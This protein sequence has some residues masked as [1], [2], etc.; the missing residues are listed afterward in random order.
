MKIEYLSEQCFMI[1]LN[2]FYLKEVSFQ[3]KIDLELYFKSFFLKLKNCY[4]ITM[5]GFY[6]IDVYKDK[7]YGMILKIK[8]EDFD[9]FDDEMIDMKLRIKDIHVLYELKD[10][11]FLKQL[12]P[13][14]SFWKD[15]HHLYYKLEEEVSYSLLGM[16]EEYT[17]L[18][19]DTGS[20]LEQAKRIRKDK[21]MHVVMLL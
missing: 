9:Y 12:I 14:G 2:K 10:E 4:G 19:I 1:Y 11:M 8:R 16:L 13:F 3:N 18:V 21:L 6:T 7:Y 5:E 20:I 15:K 17:H